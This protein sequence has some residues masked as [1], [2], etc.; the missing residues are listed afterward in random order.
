[1]YQTKGSRYLIVRRYRQCF[2]LDKSCGKMYPIFSAV[3]RQ[4]RK[5]DV[6][7]YFG[8][9]ARSTV[10]YEAGSP[11][12]DCLASIRQRERNH[13]LMFVS[14]RQMGIRY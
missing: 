2:I 12:S 6:M 1:M 7:V 11:L 8:L 13:S 5:S 9:A 3:L 10:Y 4:Q 14:F